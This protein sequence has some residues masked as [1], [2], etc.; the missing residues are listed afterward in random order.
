MSWLVLAAA[1]AAEPG[2]PFILGDDDVDEEVLVTGEADVQKARDALTLKLRSEGYR[3]HERNGEYT[4]FKA[5]TPW[6]PQVW[7]HDDGWVSLRRQPPRLH[8]PGHAFA[9]QGSPLNYLWCV[10]TLMTAC[11]SVG[12]WTIS[13]VKYHAI[14]S[15]LL[16]SVRGDVRT[17]NDAVVR[18]HLGQRVYRDIPRDLDQLWRDVTQPPEVRRRLIYLY[19]DSRLENEAGLVAKRAI[20]SFIL[21]V[22]QPGPDPFVAAE[23]ATLNAARQTL[24]PLL[25]PGVEVLPAVEPAGSGD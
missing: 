8:S 14:K 6:H 21:G 7:V 1:L 12:G 25:L 20:R 5:E 11:V 22:V 2:A 15:D 18:S 24:D 9:D 17:L 3:R 23:L 19:W 4:V 13:K 16:E 10:P